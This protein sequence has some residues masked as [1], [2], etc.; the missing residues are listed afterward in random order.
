[1]HR[2]LRQSSF[3]V[4]SLVLVGALVGCGSAEEEAPVAGPPP[5]EAVV[6]DAS[7][8]TLDFETQATWTPVGSSPSTT[9]A[10]RL[11]LLASVDSSEVER[12]KDGAVLA[13]VPSRLMIA[14]K[15]TDDTDSW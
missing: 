14:L 1:M 7:N 12:G 5:S 9:R 11:S 10:P 13:S 15:Q 8:D 2:S 3:A 6:F 4:L